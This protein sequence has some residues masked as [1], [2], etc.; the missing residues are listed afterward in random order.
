MR[1][2][3]ALLLLP[4]LAVPSVVPPAG[5]SPPA[6]QTEQ[7]QQ[8]VTALVRAGYEGDVE[9]MLR[10]THPA[11]VERL[12]GPSAARAA[13]ERVL[14]EAERVDVELESF[15][16]PRAPEFLDGRERRFAV[17][18]T[19]S[20]I[21]RGDGQRLESL[22]F[23]LGVRERRAER[24]SYV[25]GSMIDPRNVRALFPDFPEGYAFPPFHRRKL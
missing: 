10:F 24:W 1:S 15:S 16:F 4:L 17:V 5:A 9:T 2:S 8:D 7:V 14:G 19:L 22:N 6:S 25:E 12:G 23:L 18:P 13:M 21:R 20:V 11:L 3:A